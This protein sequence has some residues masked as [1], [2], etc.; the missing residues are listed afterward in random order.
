MRAFGMGLYSALT[1]QSSTVGSIFSGFIIDAFGF[2]ATFYSATFLCAIAFIIV[3]IWVPEPV[4][5]M[6]KINPKKA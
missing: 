1:Q 5:L 6:D 4:N 2:N 3:V